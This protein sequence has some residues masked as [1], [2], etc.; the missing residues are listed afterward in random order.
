MMERRTLPTRFLLLV[1]GLVAVASLPAQSVYNDRVLSALG[2]TDEEINEVLE[3]DD[4]TTSSIRRL[5]ADLE[6][7]KAE[8]ARLLVDERPNM[9]AVER[10]LRDS[11]EIEVAIR[12]L[13][14]ERELAIRQIVGTERWTAIVRAIRI[15]SAVQDRAADVAQSELGQEARERLG[16]LQREIAERQQQLLSALREGRAAANDPELR[17]Q[18]LQLQREFQELQELIRDR[19]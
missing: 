6:I 7:E 9:R 16:A 19:L 13:E 15:R 11:A 12:L 17:R 14:I 18:L 2:L 8:L 5:R 4:A 1:L 10:N 3:V